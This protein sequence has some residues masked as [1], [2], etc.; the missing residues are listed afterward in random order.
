ML[1]NIP[2]NH[3]DVYIGLSFGIFLV[4]GSS[5]NFR[6]NQ[7]KMK[8]DIPPIINRREQSENGFGQCFI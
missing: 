2:L 7:T 1:K 4:P 5:Q 3:G 6:D 8:G